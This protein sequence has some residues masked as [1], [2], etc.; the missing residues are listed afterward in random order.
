MGSVVTDNELLAGFGPVKDREWYPWKWPDQDWWAYAPEHSPE[1]YH[2]FVERVRFLAVNDFYFFCDEIIRDPIFFNKLD[3]NLHGEI[4]WILQ[5]QKDEL[6]VIPRYHLK[7]KIGTI[8]KSLWELGKNPNSRILIKAATDD[9]A[10][11]Y[12]SEIKD[13]ILQ[14]KRLQFVFP[15]LKPKRADTQ[16]KKYDMWNTGAIKVERTIIVKDPSI[17][18]AGAAS[19]ATG[20]HCDLII[21]DDLMAEKN[22]KS[23]ETTQTIIDNFDSSNYLL[24]PGGYMVTIGTRKKDDDLYGYMIADLNAKIYKRA[25]IENGEWIWNDEE[26]IAKVLRD[27]A[28]VT[29]YSFSCEMMNDPINKETQ[30]FK[31]GF[32]KQWDGDVLRKGDFVDSPPVNYEKLLDKWYR[33]LNIFL[34]CDPNRSSKKTAKSNTVILIIGVDT[35]GRMFVLKYI[36]G[37]WSSGKIVPTYCDEVEHWYNN[38]GLLKYGLETEGGDVHLVDPII[39][40]LKK[41]KI[42]ISRFQEFKRKRTEDKIDHIRTLQL[43]WERGLIWT[44]SQNHSEIEIEFNRFPMG[45]TMDIIDILA[46]MQRD[47]VKPK[48]VKKAKSRYVGGYKNRLTKNEGFNWKVA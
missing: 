4:C 41:R 31:V 11:S 44:H 32:R 47:M 22:A 45:K 9:I 1:E 18:V 29:P 17:K 26:V 3:V 43:P 46:H 10:S 27:K 7:T 25:V 34:G 28:N 2:A 12:L 42:P 39:K 21:N 36:I 19:N 16:T 23:D 33:S 14:N 6:L 20:L 35:I 37:K 40:E 30:E 38:Y 13:H 24:N 48:R 5:Y 8:C 15:D